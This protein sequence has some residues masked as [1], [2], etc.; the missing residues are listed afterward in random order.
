VLALVLFAIFRP[1]DPTTYEDEVDEDE[2]MDE[3]GRT[4]LKLK[5]MLMFFSHACVRTFV[6]ML[7]Y[8]HKI[9]SFS[10]C[11]CELIAIW[12]IYA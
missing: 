8:C 3:E 6:S 4:R 7:F 1:F 11:I 10:V 2:V 5:V 12:V 9:S